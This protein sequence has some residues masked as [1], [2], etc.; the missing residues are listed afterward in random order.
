MKRPSTNRV[1]TVS[2]CVNDEYYEV[3][4]TVSRYLPQALNQPAEQVRW[5]DCVR[6]SQHIL[7]KAIAAWPDRKGPVDFPIEGTREA[8]TKAYTSNSLWDD[9]RRWQLWY[10]MVRYLEVRV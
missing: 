6:E 1:Y 8:F 3:D 10:F 5:R 4:F 9:K 7:E 2:V